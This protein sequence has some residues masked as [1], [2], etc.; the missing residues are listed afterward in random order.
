MISR[1]K[2]AL[3]IPIFILALG[4]TSLSFT[5]YQAQVSEQNETSRRAAFEMLKSLNHLQMLIDKEYYGH[6][7]KERFI[8]GWSDILLIDDM[9]V[10]TSK[11]VRQHSEGLLALWKRSFENLDNKEVNTQ[12]SQHI[13]KTRD[14]L[15]KSVLAL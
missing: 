14:V 6:V 8:Q 12:L 11:Q 15:K 2:S 4:I 3:N 13:K 9:A 10:F 5:A 1:L 7:N